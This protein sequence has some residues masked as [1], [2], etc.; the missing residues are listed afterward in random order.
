MKKK[1]NC[2]FLFVCINFV[3]HLYKICINVLK[4]WER[5][6]KDRRQLVRESDHRRQC[7]AKAVL[8]LI[9]WVGHEAEVKCQDCSY[10]GKT[11]DSGNIEL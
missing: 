3:L 7:T 11:F 5:I 1:L 10:Q 2:F 8:H 9:F 6:N 4:K